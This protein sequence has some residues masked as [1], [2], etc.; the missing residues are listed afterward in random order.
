MALDLK[1][2][3][4]GSVTCTRNVLRYSIFPRHHAESV[5]EHSYFTALY[6]VVILKW[7][8]VYPTEKYEQPNAETVLA[9][10]LLH[11]VDESQSGDF[12][13]RFKHSDPELKDLLHRVSRRFVLKV[14]VQLDPCH[15]GPGTG[16]VGYTMVQHWDNAKDHTI[17]G[18]I[19]A[20]ADYLSVLSYI[21][22]ELE[23]GN[24]RMLETMSELSH[25]G[26]SFNGSEYDFIRP[27][28]E[29]AQ[30][31]ATGLPSSV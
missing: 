24:R 29:Q 9:R 5:A 22:Q 10:A 21:A 17:E 28:V 6:A 23:L 1:A 3:L 2:L 19:V 25:Y 26:A 20:F 18:R 16:D 8:K 30:R 13:R 11:D 4:T 14:M 7:L 12:V 27:L 15:T 31:F